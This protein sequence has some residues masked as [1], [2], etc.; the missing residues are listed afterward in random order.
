MPVVLAY[1]SGVVRTCN[2]MQRQSHFVTFTEL[3][4][5]N[6]PR[7]RHHSVKLSHNKLQMLHYKL[8]NLPPV[9]PRPQISTGIHQTIN[10]NDRK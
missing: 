2:L 7:L 9:H 5:L 4:L 10:I 3:P 8:L 6:D 1:V